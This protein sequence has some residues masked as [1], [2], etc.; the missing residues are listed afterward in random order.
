MSGLNGRSFAGSSQDEE[1]IDS[2]NRFMSENL[3]LK[4]NRLKSVSIYTVH[5]TYS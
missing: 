3:S 2:Q 4:V 5:S 1:M